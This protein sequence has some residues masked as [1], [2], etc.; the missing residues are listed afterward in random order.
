[1]FITETRIKTPWRCLNCAPQTVIL[2]L[3]P[4]EHWLNRRPSLLFFILSL[5]LPHFG[6]WQVQYF[7][8][9]YAWD[10]IDSSFFFFFYCGMI[11]CPPVSNNGLM[12]QILDCNETF[13]KF[14]SGFHIRHNDEIALLRVLNDILIWA[15]LGSAAAFRH[16]CPKYNSY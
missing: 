1:M 11:Y 3:C 13:D 12:V 10:W 4:Q 16:C 7:C 6:C 8:G 9:V 2:S 5:C 14:Q 15:N